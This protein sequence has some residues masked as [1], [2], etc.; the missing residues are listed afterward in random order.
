MALFWQPVR[1]RLTCLG[2]AVGLALFGGKGTRARADQLLRGPHPFLKE[3]ELSLHGGYTA[4]VGDAFSGARA[5]VDY[6]Y[7]LAGSWWLDMQI[8]Y[9][10]GG[11]HTGP[12]CGGGN[13]A[14]VMA[15]AK[16]KLRMDIPVVPYAKAA[17]GLLYAFPDRQ[18]SA[19]GIAMRA[20]F[21]AKYFLYDW[22]GVGAE[23]T[24]LLGHAGFAEGAG[25]SRT[26]Q[27]FD[28][29]MGVEVQF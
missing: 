9:Q 10:S 8:A 18:P 29:T 4:G 12:G 17:A 13:S 6:G 16:W 26:V 24:M 21:G 15:G 7:R 28:C 19:A 14:D 25:L 5:T 11:C 1:T 20:G 27:M 22:L 3:N 2:L 23:L